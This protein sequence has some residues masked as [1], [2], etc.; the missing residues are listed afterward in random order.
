MTPLD[1]LRE[2]LA[3]LEEE[4]GR[5]SEKLLYEISELA[6][7]VCEIIKD[8]PYGEETAALFRQGRAFFPSAPLQ[9][10]ETPKAYLFALCE[11][12]EA[13]Y[14]T[15]LVAFSVFLSERL[16]ALKKGIDPWEEKKTPARIA[17]VPA[18]SAESAYL[19]LAGIRADASVRYVGTTREAAE[20][21]LSHAA[22]YAMVPYRSADG[23]ILPAVS[24]LLNEHDL[25]IGALVSVPRG[26]AQLGYALLSTDISPF[27][28]SDRMALSVRLTAESFAHLGKMLSAI[29]AL[30]YIQTELIPEREEYGRVCAAVTLTGNGDAVALWLYLSLYS[31]GFSFLGRYPVIEL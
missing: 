1:V 11:S 29:P 15:C 8:D 7:E 6:S 2:N 26:E 4:Q 25:S 5:L 31:V 23:E 13:S 18:G 14:S 19:A 30:G 3:A 21:L 9:K 10:K 27:V 28:Y 12:G 17:Y 24:R 22:D 20:A 16:R